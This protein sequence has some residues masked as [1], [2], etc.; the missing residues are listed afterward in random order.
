MFA[1]HVLWK[2]SLSSTLLYS[3]SSFNQ[4]IFSKLHNSCST[5]SCTVSAFLAC[6]KFYSFNVAFES[7]ISTCQLL[8]VKHMYRKFYSIV[9]EHAKELFPQLCVERYTKNILL[10]FFTGAALN[11]KYINLNC[12]TV[13]SPLIRKQHVE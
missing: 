12:K 1:Y 13:L 7:E 10:I 5:S 8:V 9:F 3:M 2:K 11:K 4:S 6:Y